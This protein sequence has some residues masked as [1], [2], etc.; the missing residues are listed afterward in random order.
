MRAHAQAVVIGGGLV[1]C[2]ILYHLAKL[3][4]RDVI[5]LER[6]ELTSGSTWHAAANIHGLHDNNNITRIQ[7]YTMNLYKEL[8]A[9]TGQ[10]CGVFQPGSLYL[11]QTEER[12]RQLRLQEAKAK[13]YGLGFYEISREKA[14]ELHPLAQFE[15]VRCIMFEP[16]G[17]NVDP[18]GVTH[19]YATGAR[20]LGAEIERFCPVT[21]TEAQPDGSWIVR[22]EK[23]DIHTQWVVNAAGLWGR[24][25]AAMA[26]LTLPLQPTEHQYFVT[27]AIPE[28]EALGRRL[29]SIADRDGE[30]YFRQ[31]G[32]GLLIGAYEEK[33]KF[34]AE[35]GT[36]LDFGHE[37]FDDD[38]DRIMENVMR[39]ID[40]V[41]AA[42]E[43]GVKRVINGP[44][45]W[46]PDSNALFGPVPELTNYFCC[47]GII[48]G[49]SQ[50]G[51]LGL[52]AAQWMIEGEPEWDMFAWDLARF[53]DWADKAFTK[54]RVRDQ[55]IHRFKIHFPNEERSA[56][57]PA[58]TRP[59]FETQRAMGAVFGLNAGWEHALWFADSPDTEETVGFARQNWFGP[60]GREAAMLR[61]HVG[62]IDIS[63]FA[64]YVVEGPG[65][66]G[67][68]D[69]L[70][71]NHV[72]TEVGR[73]CLTPLIGMRG[74]VAGDFTITRTGDNGFMMIG[75]GM[76]ERYHRRF[77]N[78][79]P[80]PA[81]T[82]LE[83]A[84][85]RIAGFN[86]A[87]PKS[88]AMLA[89]LT[90]ADLSAEGWRFMRSQTI[91]VAGVECLAIRV[92]FTGDLG[93]ELHCA[94]SDQAAL[95]GALIEAASEYGGGPVG[96]RALGALRIEKGY[97]SWGREYSPEY[98]PQEAGL[99]RLIKLDK[100]FL[101][102][103][104]YMKISNTPPRETL[105][106]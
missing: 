5:L 56:G 31:E 48:P 1:G 62:I 11:A 97:G 43:A 25:V 18:S 26:G 3:G 17:G 19:A 8:E 69:A 66:H 78:M 58:R 77:F 29:P 64:N 40:R 47:N 14:L 67:W 21:G 35:D 44:M 13:F 94:E 79:V 75:S 12:E 93:W 59:I 57:R 106:M 54:A 6:D 103:D 9:E 83:N 85:P 22:T 34:W 74:G 4:W 82:T 41:P 55:Y 87:G 49:F 95:Y 30:Y 51:G 10:G 100:E 105:T 36:P 46:S 39:A 20:M 101:N 92:S 68:L 15:D 38:L 61:D 27:E 72:P 88:R 84:T 50:S 37:L 65:A 96:S 76:A 60:V 104:A 91:S 24:E 32:N 42:A 2:S 63:N 99:H 16:D 81:G 7:H 102:K 89:T 80:L 98:W 53:G 71:A 23:G 86:V 33:M 73:S 90:D 28:V 70:V 45:I 52:L